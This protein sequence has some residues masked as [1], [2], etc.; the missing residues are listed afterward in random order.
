[1]IAQETGFSRF[2]PTGDGL[3]S[4]ETEDHVLAAI[5]ELQRDYSR[6]AV[7]ARS[8]AEEYFDSDKVLESFVQKL[9]P[10]P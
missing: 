8:L 10:T 7:A 2:I 4:F 1:V 9:Q 3:F 5:E 6:H